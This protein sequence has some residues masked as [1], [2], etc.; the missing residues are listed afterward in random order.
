M[1]D[2]W[3]DRVRPRLRRLCCTIVVAENAAKS[4]APPNAAAGRL[5][6][7][8]DQFVAEALMVAFAMIENHKL[9]ECSA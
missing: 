2:N 5:V 3:A 8:I 4:L 1:S 6:V 7:T 9:R